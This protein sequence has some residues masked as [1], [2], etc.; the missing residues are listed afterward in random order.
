VL[1]NFGTGTDGSYPG[2]GVVLDGFGNIYGTTTIGG[3]ASLG[4]VWEVTP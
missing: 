2:G 3:T 1:H 4:T